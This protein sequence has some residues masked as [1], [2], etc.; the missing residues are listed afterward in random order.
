MAIL[1]SVSVFF[2]SLLTILQYLN[3]ASLNGWLYFFGERSF[4][5]ST[6]GIANAAINGELVLRPY[7][8]FS[9]SNVLS[10]YLLLCTVIIYFFQI[11]RTKGFIRWF[12]VSVLL[13]A[14]IAIL[15]S[16]SRVVIGLWLV[17]CFILVLYQ[18]IIRL[19]S[20][21]AIA[22]GLLITLGA[23]LI[24][25]ASPLGQTLSAR[26]IQTSFF[27]EALVQR[28]ELIQTSLLLIQ[29]NPLIGVGL[30]NF[31][32]S[33]APLLKPLSI[34][35]YLQ[36]VHNIYLL[37]T[38]ETGLIGLAGFVTFIVLTYHRLFEKIQTPL[39]RLD[40]FVFTL[41]L[42]L[43]L[44]IGFFDHYFVTLQ[45]GQLLFSLILGLC[46]TILIQ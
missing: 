7:A 6:L 46:W 44:I 28:S 34:G 4:T 2:E 1:M 27:E 40:F 30:G 37:L 9:H 31:I 24:S 38:T 26:F 45:Q 12:G 25:I 39:F 3:Q 36:P 5:G 33:L 11:R 14:S 22:F 32:P 42:T 18:V 23:V 43:I 15:L 21:H 10:G 8:T 41:L 17:L 29:A 19:R 35:L 20:I 16:L 13:L